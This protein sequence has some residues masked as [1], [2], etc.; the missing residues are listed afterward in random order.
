M[1]TNSNNSAYQ[2]YGQVRNGVKIWK[3]QN[4][5]SAV[6][7]THLLNSYREKIK[8]DESKKESKEMRYAGRM[9]FSVTSNGKYLKAYVEKKKAKTL[10]ASIVSGSFSKIYPAGFVDF[11]GSVEENQIFAS[12]LEIKP[13]KL[14][15]K[16]KIQIEIQKM[17]GTRTS[18]GAYKPSG[19]AI[20]KTNTLLDPD[21]FLEMAVEV[22]DFIKAAEMAAMQLK[23]PM[24][25]LINYDYEK[26]NSSQSP[27]PSQ[28]ATVEPK[29]E[30]TP[31]VLKDMSGQDFHTLYLK[32]KEEFSKCQEEYD[33]RVALKIERDAVKQ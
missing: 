21:Q 33:R 1:S 32:T 24:N 31:P 25:T 19:A 22:G 4:Q 15:D 3:F 28:G 27:T 10:F 30:T 5:K 11:G 2:S 6:D 16:H 26:I 18:T 9:C 7:I 14:G 13:V 8:V 20:A 23:I 12:K 29:K 17:P